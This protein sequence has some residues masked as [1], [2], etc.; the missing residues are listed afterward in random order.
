MGALNSRTDRLM[1]ALIA[2]SA[3]WDTI[4]R[5]NMRIIIT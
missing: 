3:N 2:N 4:A 5:Q 1:G